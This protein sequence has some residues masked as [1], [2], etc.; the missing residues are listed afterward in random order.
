MR[1]AMS[2]TSIPQRRSN[3][4]ECS[5]PKPIG[6]RF[7]EWISRAKRKRAKSEGPIVTTTTGQ[8]ESEGCSATPAISDL[9]AGEG[10]HDSTN[11]QRYTLDERKPLAYK[12]Y[13]NRCY[14]ICG[15][16]FGWGPYCKRCEVIYSING[17]QPMPRADIKRFG[18]WLKDAVKRGTLAPM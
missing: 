11:G 9:L 10:T 15:W 2:P 1:Q 12:L 8:G 14:G 5:L 7:V 13:C 16:V 17:P 6:V 18:M 3:E 4:S